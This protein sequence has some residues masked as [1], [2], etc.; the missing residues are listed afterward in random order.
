MEEKKAPKLPMTDIPAAANQLSYEQL[1]TVASQYA[2]HCEKLQTQLQEISMFNLFK[3]LEYLFKVVE[4]ESS[5]SE[6]FVNSTIMEIEKAM[7]SYNE[8]EGDSEDTKE[9]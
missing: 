1:K 8:V 5:F 2:K 7:S 4:F 9:E 6:K 3:R